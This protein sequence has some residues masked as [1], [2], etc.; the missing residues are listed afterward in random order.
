[1]LKEPKVFFIYSAKLPEN[2]LKAIKLLLT[3][4]GVI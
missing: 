3:N 4:S 2:F 1:M